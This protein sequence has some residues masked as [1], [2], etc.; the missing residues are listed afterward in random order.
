MKIHRGFTIIE[1]LV[2]LGL[3]MIIAGIITQVFRPTTYFQKTRDI[4]RLTDLKNLEIA[5]RTYLLAT[6]S[7]ILGPINRAF[8]EATPTVFISVPF[9]KED[10]RTLTFT[11]KEKIF[12]LNQVSSTEIFKNTGQGWLPINFNALIFPPLTNLPL[13]PINSFNNN[14]FFYSYVFHR[15]SS[16]FE[17]NAKLEFSLYNYQGNDDKT[18]TDNGDNYNIYELGTDKSL[19]PNPLYD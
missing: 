10:K 15:A 7:P 1:I 18:G 4:K 8:D 19:I 14:K 17:L 16:T 13:D 5:I 3:I 9:D 11:W 2:T 12:R 6:D